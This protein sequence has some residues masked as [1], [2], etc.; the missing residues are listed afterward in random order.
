MVLNALFN[1]VLCYFCSLRSCCWS[2]SKPLLSSWCSTVQ[3]MT[4]LSRRLMPFLDIQKNVRDLWYEKS[5]NVPEIKL[6]IHY[7][8]YGFNFVTQYLSFV[9]CVAGFLVLSIICRSLS[10]VECVTGFLV[11]SIICRSL[12]FLLFLVSRRGRKHILFD[13][14]FVE[15]KLWQSTILLYHRWD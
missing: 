6:I 5:T 12:G 11:L 3:K 2:R 7:S 4:L 10:F 15:G 1:L 13:Q 14:R 8:Q 9:E